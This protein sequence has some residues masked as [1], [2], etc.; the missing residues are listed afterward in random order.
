MGFVIIKRSSTFVEI[1]NQF[2]G[3]IYSFEILHVIPFDSMRKRMSIFVKFVNSE[4]NPNMIYLFTKGS[5]DALL[6]ISNLSEEVYSKATNAI[7]CFKSESSRVIVFSMKSVEE[8]EFRDWLSKVQNI[9]EENAL[10]ELN[11]QMENNLNFK[12][13]CT[14]NNQMKPGISETVNSLMKNG[15]N[16]CSCPVSSKRAL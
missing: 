16:F 2:T 3:K 4:T 12:G 13:I 7:E 10:N 6:P 9:Q 11:N 15:K 14:L 8:N 1:K 5:P